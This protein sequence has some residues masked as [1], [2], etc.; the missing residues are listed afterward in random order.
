MKLRNTIFPL[1]ALTLLG[2]C[3]DQNDPDV[4]E[5]RPTV[6]QSETDS[7]PQP[8]EIGASE[9]LVRLSCADFLDTATV[10]TDEKDAEAAMAAQDEI[11]NGLTWLHGF[12]YAESSGEIEVLSQDW[13]KATVERV[14]ESCSAAEDPA[15]TNLFEVARS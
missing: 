2:A 1:A 9:N 12:L 11:A 14:Y 5:T 13:M 15:N 10:A 4:E 7:N 6:E 8:I 3:A